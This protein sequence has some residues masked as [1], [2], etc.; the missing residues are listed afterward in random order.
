MKLTGITLGLGLSVSLLGG[1]ASYTAH[2]DL[3]NDGRFDVVSGQHAEGHFF[4]ADFQLNEKLSRPDETYQEKSLVRFRG[5]PDEISFADVDGDGDLDLRCKQTS[6]TRWDYI[7]DG[8]YVALNDGTG[9][10]GEL[11]SIEAVMTSLNAT[12]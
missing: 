11:E 12:P 6:Q 9:N 4:Y 10:F 3:N 8:E 2:V 5:K 1:C 7:V